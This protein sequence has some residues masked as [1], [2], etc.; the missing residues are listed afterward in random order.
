[1]TQ[2]HASTSPSIDDALLARLDAWRPFT[3]IVVGDFILD[4]MVYGDAERLSPDAPV[5]VLLVRSREFRPGGSAN[6][7]M[8]LAALHARVLAFG[9]TGEDTA[10][11]RLRDALAK[12]GID[13]AG[14]IADDTRPT[15]LKQNLIGLAQARH[16]QK[17]FRVD[18]EST[19][20]LSPAVQQRLLERIERAMPSADV[21]ILE[22]YA[23][24]VCDEALCQRVIA[25]ARALGKPVFVDP[26]RNAP[27]HRY[28]G[29]TTITPNRTEA[30]QLCGRLPSPARGSEPPAMAK[31]LLDA[32]ELECCVLTLDRH[33]ALLLERGRSDASTVPTLAREVYDVSGAGDMFLAALAAARANGCTWTQSVHV[34]NAAAGLEVEVFGVQPIPFASV[35]ESLVRLSGAGHA[36]KLRSV[37]QV[38]AEVSD[39][40]RRGKRVVFTNGCFDVLHSG[41]VTLLEKAA[42]MGDYLVVGLNSDASVRRLKGPTRPVNT[43]DDR[44]RVLGALACVGAVV[45]FDHDRAGNDTPLDLIETILP[46]VLVKGGDYTRASVVGADVVERHGGRVELVPLVEGKSTTATL[47]RASAR[48]GERGT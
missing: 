28:R 10:A 5:P 37:A 34:A 18:E 7:C 45:V 27:P 26:A 19:Q 24:G 38:L 22:D 1:M 9:V 15:T 31:A 17:M 43:Q 25:L 48:A 32:M 44:A 46:E 4:E 21:V 8:D 14:L 42:A 35:R 11:K 16:P 47:Q 29:A 3:A 33:G 40:R 12:E 13:T 41:H 2:P 39:L 30:Q 36:G 20:P 23:K 6:V